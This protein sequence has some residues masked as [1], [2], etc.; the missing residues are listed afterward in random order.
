[1]L[2]YNRWGVHQGLSLIPK[3]VSKKEVK[4]RHIDDEVGIF[5]PWRSIR[6]DLV[7]SE[8]LPTR[9]VLTT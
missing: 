8:N 5:V 3:S 4:E 1:M 7:D 6:F 2:E 9:F